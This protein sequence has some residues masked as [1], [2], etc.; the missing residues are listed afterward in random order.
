MVVHAA[1]QTWF[2]IEENA[3]EAALSAEEA[4]EEK[5]EV[6]RS[7]V[8]ASRRSSASSASSRMWPVAQ[9]IFTIKSKHLA[10]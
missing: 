2:S 3:S 9:A 4:T 7:S 8:L 10:L 5:P 6:T 1:L